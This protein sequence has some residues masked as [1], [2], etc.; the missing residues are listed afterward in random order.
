MS[1]KSEV[2]D[3]LN[4]MPPE[5]DF[6]DILYQVYVMREI[7]E[8]L[9]AV[10]EGRVVSQEEAKRRYQEWRKSYGQTPRSAT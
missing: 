2:L 6:D 1:A 7:N 8:G 3:A 5:S 4:K 9:A 10:R